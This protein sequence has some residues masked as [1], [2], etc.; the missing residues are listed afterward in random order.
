[1]GAKLLG[2]G[3]GDPNNHDR[4]ED[5]R[6]RLFRGRC[7]IIL[8]AEDQE[9]LQVTLVSEKLGEYTGK[10]EIRRAEDEK[11]ILSVDAVFVRC[12]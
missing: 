12:V 10:W 1:M 4:E 11:E 7:Q 6:V 5:G 3:N 9:Y 2:A 8:Q